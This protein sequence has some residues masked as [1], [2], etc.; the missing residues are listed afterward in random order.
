MDITAEAGSIFDNH[1]RHKNKARLLDI[2]IFYSCASFN[3]WNT[4]RHAGKHLTD[5][6][7]QTKR[8]YQGSFPATYFL[9]PLGLSMS[10]EA[11]SHLHALTK[12]F[13]TRRVEHRSEIHSNESQ[14]LPEGK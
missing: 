7:D 6:V 9:L 1:P 14:H 11:G 12:E 2:T 10:G 13:T 4:E 5:A 8:K 3:L